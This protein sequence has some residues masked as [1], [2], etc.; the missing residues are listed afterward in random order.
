[1]SINNVD[2]SW[3]KQQR[4][5]TGTIDLKPVLEK[6]WDD[7]S[8]K[9]KEVFLNPKPG[10][11]SRKKVS[12][13][14]FRL[15]R[16][17]RRDGDPTPTSEFIDR[18]FRPPDPAGGR[19]RR[20]KGKSRKSKK[21]RRKKRRTKKGGDD[22][23]NMS[24]DE[25]SIAK[26]TALK[27]AMLA[28]AARDHEQREID[29]RTGFFN[30]PRS[31][32]AKLRQSQRVSRRDIADATASK[33]IEKARGI[34]EAIKRQPSSSSQFP[35]SAPGSFP[36]ASKR[37][38]NPSA[39]MALA[40]HNTRA[41]AAVQEEAPSTRQASFWDLLQPKTASYAGGR[42]RKAKKSKKTKRSRRAR[43]TRK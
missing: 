39:A 18:N 19:K 16:A 11:F 9:T 27:Q 21:S 37:V 14:Y 12:E 35:R 26:Q 31:T 8:N 42:K 15:E 22:L 17:A 7:L 40:E 43:R 6:V 30:K 13:D 3:L 5:M 28:R 24:L 4:V 1:M 10:M 34:L 23:T 41:R 32:D 20:T 25:L 29:A 2:P 36:Q 33:E 38:L